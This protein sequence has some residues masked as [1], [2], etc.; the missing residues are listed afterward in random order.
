MGDRGSGDLDKL[1]GT[2]WPP[3]YCS[4][5]T[6][7]ERLNANRKSSQGGLGRLHGVK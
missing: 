2:W 3:P 1:R 7:G 4:L 6:R 5:E